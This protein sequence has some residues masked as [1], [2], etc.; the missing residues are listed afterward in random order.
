MRVI[1][2]GGTRFI[3]RAIVDALMAAGHDPLICHRGV[4]KA[5]GL[6]AVAHLHAE[7]AE[8]GEHQREL[9]AFDAEAVI[10]CYAMSARDARAL[11]V[12][13]PDPAQ[14]R[15]VLSSQDVYRAFA[16]VQRNGLAT[17]AVPITEDAPL[18]ADRFPSRGEEGYEEYSKLEVE[19]AVLAAGAT[20][21]RLPMV[22]G[23][24]DYQRREEFV[25][26]RVRAG[27][28]R[29]PVGAANA[30]LPLALVDDV[31]RGVVA[32]VEHRARGATIYNL[33]PARTDP[34]A[35]WMRRILAAADSPAE[36]VR[37]PDGI[38]LPGDLGLTV[39]FSQPL[40]ISSA[41]ARH[42]LGYQDTDPD[43]AVSR[44]VRWHLAHPPEDVSGDFSADDRALAATEAS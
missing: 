44:S 8:L 39:A 26:K 1:V 23:P 6:P 11:L 29:I 32:A 42:E 41:K 25:L 3:G 5:D 28:L 18:R 36:L 33:G 20:V 16:T 38:P 10:D 37:V 21:L 30:L 15:V 9:E 31:G 40:V 22:Y 35:V 34:M 2:L 12:A 43:E 17:D 24:Y 13:L 7:R 14:H 19:E 4:T 27:R